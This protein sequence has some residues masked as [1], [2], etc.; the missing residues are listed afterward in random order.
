MSHDPSSQEYFVNPFMQ[1]KNVAI[2][3]VLLAL[4]RFVYSFHVDETDYVHVM[5]KRKL[6]KYF[7]NIYL[8]V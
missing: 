6:F 3:V 7:P 8:N 5:I 1:G 4:V 2:S